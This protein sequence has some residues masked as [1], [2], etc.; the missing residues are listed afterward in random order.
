VRLIIRK[1]APGA[2]NERL[3][4]S[5]NC[6]HDG[7]LCKSGGAA[8]PWKG[9]TPGHVAI[10]GGLASY[11]CRSLQRQPQD[12]I[13]YY[14]TTTCRRPS[15]CAGLQLRTPGIMA[16]GGRFPAAIVRP[17]VWPM[18]SGPQSRSAAETLA[19]AAAGLRL[20][21]LLPAAQTGQY[22]AL[23][24]SIQ[25]T[26]FAPFGREPGFRAGAIQQPRRRSERQ[27]HRG[28]TTNRAIPGKHLATTWP[29]GTHRGNPRTNSLAPR[30]GRSSPG[31]SGP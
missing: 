29:A 27:S 15:T 4:A 7:H 25:A 20:M 9:S 30:T 19:H 8:L 16:R 2:R 22:L 5:C 17:A 10:F 6:R 28:G 3:H 14:D 26:P 1:H 31:S 13:Y 11:S 23:T 21:L 24:R 12:T 18:S